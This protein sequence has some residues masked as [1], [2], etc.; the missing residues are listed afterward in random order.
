[1]WKEQ[2]SVTH[3]NSVHVGGRF[4]CLIYIE[5]L[6]KSVCLLYPDELLLCQLGLD[7]LAYRYHPMPSS[8]LR[9]IILHSIA[10]ALVVQG[11]SDKNAEIEI[12]SRIMYF[13]PFL[14]P[15]PY[16]NILMSF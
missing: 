14:P 12:L 3:L 7:L 10:K 11:G 16:G 2:A 9:A 8:Y 1:M 5:R 15:Y 4:I 13:R 6:M